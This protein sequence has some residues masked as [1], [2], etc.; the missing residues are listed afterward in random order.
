MEKFL[1]GSFYGEVFMGKFIVG[2]GVD[3]LVV[4]K[5]STLERCLS[6][7]KISKILT[8]AH[9]FWKQPYI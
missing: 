1:W 6:N 2:S 5:N 4:A 8:I 9:R 3:R 7:V